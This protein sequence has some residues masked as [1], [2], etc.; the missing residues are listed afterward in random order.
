MF[1][2]EKLPFQGQVIGAPIPPVEGAFCFHIDI[3]TLDKKKSSPTMTVELD[4]F[5]LDNFMYHVSSCIIVSFRHPSASTR[6]NRFSARWGATD[7]WSCPTGY[8]MLFWTRSKQEALCALTTGG[9]GGERTVMLCLA[10]YQYV[11]GNIRVDMTKHNTI[12]SRLGDRGISPSP[13]RI[14]VSI[15]IV[16]LL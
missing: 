15:A 5:L 16:Y 1:N 10:Y 11:Y 9:H 7:R 6:R 13:R 12:T 8:S 4:P 2:I 3:Y 14:Q